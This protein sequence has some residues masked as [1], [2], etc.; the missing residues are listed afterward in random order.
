MKDDFVVFSLEIIP[1][2][3]G[4]GLPHTTEHKIT[5]FCFDVSG[6]VCRAIVE[7]GQT[8]EVETSNPMHCIYYPGVAYAVDQVQ[9]YTRQ[10]CLNQIESLYGFKQTEYWVDEEVTAD[11]SLELLREL[12][13]QQLLNDSRSSEVGES[14]A[15]RRKIDSIAYST[16]LGKD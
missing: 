8:V 13:I 10:S 3:D 6:R 5:A 9:C 4:R 14:D 1:T 7:S 15:K 16:M 12:A 2:L 11:S